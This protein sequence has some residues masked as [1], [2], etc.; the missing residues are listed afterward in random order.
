MIVVF[1]GYVCSREAEITQSGSNVCEIDMAVCN[2]REVI[3]TS[4][5]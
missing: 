5:K 2:A 4:D 3:T 1:C